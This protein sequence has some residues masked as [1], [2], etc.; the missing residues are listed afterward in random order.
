[1]LADHLDLTKLGIT[2][3]VLFTTLAGLWLASRG[4]SLG[5]T[6]FAPLNTALSGIALLVELFFIKRGNTT[7]R[8]RIARVTLL[9]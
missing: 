2:A 6:F 9:L 1:V 4:I 5:L 8:K 3:M 7:S